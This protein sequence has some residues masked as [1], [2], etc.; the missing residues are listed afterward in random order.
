MVMVR[1]VSSIRAAIAGLA[2]SRQSFMMDAMQSMGKS[3]A[4]AWGHMIGAYSLRVVAGRLE[5]MTPEPLPDTACLWIGWHEYNLIALAVHRIIV[6]RPV[7]AFVPSRGLGASTMRG[8]L[9][10]L[11]VAP[12]SIIPGTEASALRRMVTA[13]RNGVDAMVAM[14]GPAGPRRVARKGIFSLAVHTNVKI[15]AI[16]VAVWPAVRLPRWDRHLIP[17]PMARV[18][19]VFSSDLRPRLAGDA[20]EAIRGLAD[21]LIHLDQQ[22]LDFSEQAR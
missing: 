14:D 12:I 2:W 9:E 18:T 3:A 15:R 20:D 10:R 6:K 17:L 1:A 21:H 22:A 19:V 8:W 13:L 7:T 5:M 16:G 4:D 11:D